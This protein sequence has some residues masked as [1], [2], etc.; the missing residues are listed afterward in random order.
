MSELLKKAYSPSEFAEINES[1]SH[2]IKNTL[3]IALTEQRNVT[4]Y[5]S[6]DQLYHQWKEKEYKNLENLTQDI[7]RQS[8][9]IHHPKYVGH[10]VCMPLPVSAVMSMLGSHLNNGMAV[11]EM[12]MAAS[13]IDRLMVEE[14]N[15]YFGYGPE[16]TGIFTSGG[17]IANITALLCA[18]AN[19]D[20]HVWK[21]GTK[22]KLGFM[23]S[24][25][26][27]YCIDRAVRIMGLGEDGMVLIPSDH[28]YVAD[29]HLLDKV[30]NDAI[31]RGI[32]VIG[33]V[34]SAP[35]T[36]TGRYDDLKTI[37][38]F[39]LKN[40]LWFHIDAA[41]GGPA[42]LSE[43]YKHLMNGCEMADSITVDAHKMMMMPALTT[44]LLF[45]R[46][47]DS[48]KTFAQE[49]SYLFSHEEL[50]WSNFGKRTMECTKIM[51]GMRLY[52]AWKEYG[53]QLFIDNLEKCYD[54]AYEFETL[55][56]ENGSFELPV[57]PHSNIV[58]FRIKDASNEEI[59]TIREKMLQ[60]GTFYLLKTKLRDTIYFRCSLM[61]PFTSKADLQSMIDTILTEFNKIRI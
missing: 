26:A 52:A 2:L 21:T 12:G 44:M 54:L 30:Y 49:A 59:E 17:T 57:S 45:K 32:K 1:I 10:Q 23:V 42:V 47:K 7:V 31:N 5:V 4:N 15:P 3:D 36:A 24:D 18:R 20:P 29:V 41:H 51:L 35:S 28:N 6:P 39:A 48:Y 11:Y 56:L 13:V 58:C 53:V 33:I 16:S 27:H 19:H 14:I 38:A 25:Q 34:G 43:K 55:L 40:K 61:N 46:H 60:D 8:V 37:G 50:D 22:E 9:L